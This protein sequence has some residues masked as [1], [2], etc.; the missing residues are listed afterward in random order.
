MRF[1]KLNK[2]RVAFWFA[3]YTTHEPHSLCIYI[4]ANNLQGND[5][6]ETVVR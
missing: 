1:S 6:M 5:I 3:C 4:Y 2:Q